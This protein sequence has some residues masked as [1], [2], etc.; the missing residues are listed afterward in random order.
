MSSLQQ[1]ETLNPPYPVNHRRQATFNLSPRNLCSTR[2]T[3]RRRLTGRPS[4]RHYPSQSS[5]SPA[6]QSVPPLHQPYRSANS[7]HPPIYTGDLKSMA[8]LDMLLSSDHRVPHVHARL[9]LASWITKPSL[10]RCAPPDTL[11]AIRIAGL[12]LVHRPVWA[13]RP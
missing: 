13:V 6:P 5:T 9:F 11:I 1:S 3:R 8:R 12:N 7:Y 2:T 4:L 10:C